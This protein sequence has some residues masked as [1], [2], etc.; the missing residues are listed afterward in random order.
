MLLTLDIG[1]TSTTIGLFDNDRLVET[2]SIA[3][4]KHRSED[5]IGI[6]LINLL[7]IHNYDNDIVIVPGMIS[8]TYTFFNV[9]LKD[10]PY[11][12]VFSS[13]FVIEV[14]KNEVAILLNVLNGE[15]FKEYLRN[16]GKIWKGK[17]KEHSYYSLTIKQL[18]KLL[19]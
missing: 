14:S 15:N 5:E 1:N 13:G 7:K 11:P 8:T 4:E 9:S 12:F 19:G 18:K 17:D 16:Y 6:L 3:S 2:W 10:I